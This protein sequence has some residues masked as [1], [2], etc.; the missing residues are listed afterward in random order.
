M[1]KLIEMVKKLQ[2]IMVRFL[3][4]VKHLYGHKF[5]LEKGL[6]MS[7]QSDQFHAYFP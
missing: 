7:F 4:G 2:N 5:H 1:N 3:H 6:E